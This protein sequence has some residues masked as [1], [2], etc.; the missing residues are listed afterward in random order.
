MDILPTP[1]GRIARGNTIVFVVGASITLVA[2]MTLL[3]ILGAT[4]GVGRGLPVPAGGATGAAKTIQPADV[5]RDGD[6]LLA[7][8]TTTCGIPQVGSDAVPRTAA[9]QYCV[10]DVTVTNAGRYPAVFQLDAQSMRDVDGVDRHAD[11]LASVYAAVGGDQVSTWVRV[12]D[13]GATVTG[14]V[15][16]DLPVGAVPASVTLRAGPLSPGVTIKADREQ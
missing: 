2:A 8:S 13:P 6:L 4:T 15:V 1:P 5:G 10:V 3:G 9:G 16:F 11:V 14:P 7:A 12:I